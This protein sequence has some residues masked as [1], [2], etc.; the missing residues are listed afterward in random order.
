M[1]FEPIFPVWLLIVVAVVLIGVR[2]AALYRVL[3]RTGPGRYR[4]VVL[5]WSGLTLAVLLLV[6]AAARPSLT[7]D[8]GNGPPPPTP[9]SS[10]ANF[11]VFFVVDRS[12]DERVEDLA[13]QTSRMA[14]IRSDIA[15]LA[16]QFPRARFA[17]IG[18]AAKAAQDWP[19]SDDVWSLKPRV[20]GLST[21]TE[22]PL[23]AMY[24]VDSGAAQNV[25]HDKLTQ[26]GADFP[27]SKNLVFYLGSGAGGSRAQQTPFDIGE[28]LVAGG[29]VL[30]YGTP[31][32]GPI[33]QQYVDGN[34]IYMADQQ[35]KAPLNSSID[36]ATLK[37]I[38]GQLGVPYFHRDKDQPITPVIP[39]VDPGHP[40]DENPIVASQTI[41][42]TELYW[43]FTLLAAALIAVEVFLGIRDVRRARSTQ[44]D[45]VV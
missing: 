25:L 41:E 38:A 9:A 5:R 11:N 3:V 14:G 44:R 22:T 10:A 34:L 20:A 4:P 29:A 39:A 2:M 40:A 19:L 1:K 23:E 21:Y 13:P 36:E 15:A 8:T 27:G 6:V 42:R 12:A 26:A 32:G 17:M 43:L 37:G 18:F 24:V 7:P 31:E 35:T 33:P 45:V 28:D 16:D 30:G